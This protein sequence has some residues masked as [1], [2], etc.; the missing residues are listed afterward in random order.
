MLSLY[1]AL[2]FYINW[3]I[4]CYGSGLSF[5]SRF[6]VFQK[7]DIGIIAKNAA[8]WSSILGGFIA[9]PI[10]AK[11]GINKCLWLFG[12]IQLASIVGFWFLSETGPDKLLFAFVVSFEYLGV[13]L[14][15]ASY[16]AYIA[17]ETNIQFGCNL[18][19]LC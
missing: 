16:I 12:F 3:V 19:L 7:T 11:L 8:L 9:I 5:L 6:R 17:R 1:C 10:I 4:V 13:G 18:N 14:G 15:T 2:Y